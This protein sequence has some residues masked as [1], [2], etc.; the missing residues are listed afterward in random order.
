MANT[1][2]APAIFVKEVRRNRDRKNVFFAHA[3]RDCEGE[4]KNAGDVVRVQTLPT[5]SFTATAITGAGDV[6]N[7]DVGT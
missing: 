2:I 1:I 4:I 7:A 5:L 6:T 3:N